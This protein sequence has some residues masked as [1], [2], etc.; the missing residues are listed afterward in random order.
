MCCDICTRFDECEE[1][2]KLKDNCCPECSDY[3]SCR[4]NN[5]HDDVIDSFDDDDE[6]FRKYY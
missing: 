4:E 5:E 3:E 1:K 2:G 6:K